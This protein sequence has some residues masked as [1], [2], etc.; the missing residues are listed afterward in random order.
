MDYYNTQQPQVQRQAYYS[1]FQR[2]AGVIL[3]NKN[4]IQDLK[5]SGTL[6]D[7]AFAFLLSALGLTGV[8]IINSYLT[9]K[10]L[11]FSD[12]PTNT[13]D[14]YGIDVA[15]VNS[16]MRMV[17]PTSF[18]EH[19][20]GNLGQLA[21][22]IIGL[23]IFWILASV[24][25]HLFAIGLKGQARFTNIFV[26]T[27]FLAPIS[28]FFGLIFLLPI[29][30]GLYGIWYLFFVLIALFIFLMIILIRASIRGLSEIYALTTSG[31]GIIF[32]LT[33]IIFLIVAAVSWM[34]IF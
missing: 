2:V 1:F 26:F 6:I 32:L 15:A 25:I 21:I 23:S 33:A 20:V 27:A 9:F 19:L 3:G 8:F 10:S 24:L 34:V 28:I 7:A 17:I 5:Q 4:V 14:Q 30:S 11:S 12:L 16:F 13:L 31:A 29:I 18:S 22:L